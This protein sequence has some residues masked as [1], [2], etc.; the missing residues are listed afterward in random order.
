MSLILDALR[1]SEQER[2]E[3]QPPLGDLKRLT[4]PASRRRERYSTVAVGV[5]TVALLTLLA[6]GGWWFRAGPPSALAP[7]S[8]AAHNPTPSPAELSTRAP[9]IADTEL[10]SA[11]SEPAANTRAEQPNHETA[12][13]A[14]VPPSPPP[15]PLADEARPLP[16]QSPTVTQPE[17][18]ITAEA[19]AP[20]I[21]RNGSDPARDPVRFREAPTEVQA[22]LAGFEINT[23]YYAQAPGRGFALINMRKYRVGDTL[24]RSDYRVQAITATG[25]VVDDGRHAVLLEVA[26]D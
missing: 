25:V 15:R 18:S 16:A 26:P 22:R 3:Q 19:T 17:P 24:E 7:E 13:A 14:P 20:P 5:F 9:K 6:A 10:L 23:H 21:R 8:T 12:R 1:R 2:S 11:A 4:H